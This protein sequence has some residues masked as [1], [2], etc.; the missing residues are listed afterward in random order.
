MN[1][2]DEVTLTGF[3]GSRSL[4]FRFH[5]DVNFIIGTNGSGKT[6]AVKLIV[7]ALTADQDELLKLDFSKII[8]KLRSLDSNKKPLITITK[9][10]GS[11]G[12]TN[13]VRYDIKQSLNEASKKY[14]VGYPE[15]EWQNYVVLQKYYPNDSK[16]SE[17]VPSFLSDLVNVNWLSVQRE[18]VRG[19][20]DKK[21]EGSVDRKL[22][23]LS[24]RLVRYF[25][26][27]SKQG[28]E[29]LENLQKELFISM[30]VG[31]DFKEL[32]L[33]S[34]SMNLEAK[35]K[36]LEGIFKQFNLDQKSFQSKL[37]DHFNVLEKAKLK[38]EKDSSAITENDV[39]ALIGTERIN[40][41]VEEWQKLLEKR[42][43]LFESRD[44]YLS[45]INNMMQRKT[46]Q[47]ND[48]NELEI[49]TQSGK[50]LPI[51][52]L[53]SGEKQ[54][55]ILLGEALLQE[56]KTCVYI[57]DE[58]ELSLHVRWQEKLVDNLRAINPNAQIIFAT[59]SPD[60][61][62]HFNENIFD[63]ENIIK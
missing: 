49:T 8:I 36:A 24:N 17:P 41:I 38:L 46:F 48:Q 9:F 61:V 52:N 55:L 20:G 50:K 58:P 21:F 47:I 23:E 39:L 57:A 6:T 42:K 62:S 26:S 44:T 28:T 16:R 43:K 51:S 34:K 31:M 40:Y 56:K 54:I 14:V 53:S 13:F 63:M 4:Y 37:D 29:L 25:S 45:I 33:I 15:D 32:T 7:A 30:L 12:I 1:I 35:K 11:R 60:I 59:H 18:S 27:I 3:W 2:L 5:N 22:T 10:L 19:E